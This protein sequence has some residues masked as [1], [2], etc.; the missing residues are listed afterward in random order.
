[1]LKRNATN[2]VRVQ[3]QVEYKPHCE[4]GKRPGGTGILTRFCLIGE[5]SSKNALCFYL[6]TAIMTPVNRVEENR[7]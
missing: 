4:I 3:T 2:Y 6:E 1:M 7:G 5:I